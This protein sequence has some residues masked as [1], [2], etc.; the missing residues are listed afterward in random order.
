MKKGVGD[1]FQQETKY[2]RGQTSRGGLDWAHVPERAKSYPRAPRV[3]L[4]AP[5]REGGMPLW[6]TLQARR[7][8]RDFGGGPIGQEQLS[9]LLWT[10]QGVTKVARELDLRTAPSAGAL[11]PVETYVAVFKVDGIPPGIYHYDVRQH[12]LEQLAAGDHRNGVVGAALD[13]D[14]LRAAGVV[15]IWTA[16]FG[17]TKWKYKQRAY[18]YVYL[19]TGQVAQN[20]ALGAVALGLGSCQVGAIY[21]GE[22]NTL[23]GV[24]GEEESVVCMAAVGMPVQSAA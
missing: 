5:R 10:A 13:Q 24:D 9:Q 17:R 21:D 19:D 20:L 8:C 18:R 16:V 4:E 14:F 6:E 7:S 11:Y 15:F 12:E 3:K 2:V 23:I 1:R 22:A